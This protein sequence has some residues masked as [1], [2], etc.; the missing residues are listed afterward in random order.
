MDKLSKR[1][2]AAHG[3]LMGKFF[4]LLTQ[5]P[6]EGDTIIVNDLI[7]VFN[8]KVVIDKQD[9]EFH[10]IHLK[11]VHYEGEQKEFEKMGVTFSKPH[12]GHPQQLIKKARKKALKKR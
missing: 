12:Q 5:V 9:A 1:I 2:W 7:A 11:D 4:V 8:K 6:V 10:G 3:V